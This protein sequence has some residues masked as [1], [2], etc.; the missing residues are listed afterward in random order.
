M[1]FPGMYGGPGAG[2]AGSTAGMN[3]QEQKMVKMMSG[4]MESCLAKSIMAGVMGGVLGG[5]FGLFMSSVSA[6]PEEGVDVLLFF[7]T[8]TLKSNRLIALVAC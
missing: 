6:V 7:G 5:A 4:A 3:E 8:S 1:S 2:G